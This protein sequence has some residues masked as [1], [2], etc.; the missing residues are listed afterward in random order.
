MAHAPAS[1]PSSRNSGDG[2]KGKPR[3]VA[4]IT[5]ITG[6][7]SAGRGPAACGP[8]AR[9]SPPS[10]AQGRRGTGNRARRVP[11]GVL[12]PGVRRLQ[13]ELRGSLLALRG[14]S[15]CCA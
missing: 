4:L 5:G 9:G 2:D 7:V 10:A 12:G 11:E 8:G 1:C 6:Q 15:L 3:K 13:P 14:V